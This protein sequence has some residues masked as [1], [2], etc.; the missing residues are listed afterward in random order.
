M[1]CA[2]C[3]AACTDLTPCRQLPE[4]GGPAPEPAYNVARILTLSTL[5][6]ATLLTTACAQPEPDASPQDAA[7][8][9]A[10]SPDWPEGRLDRRVVPTAY[11]LELEILPEQATFEGR[12]R[13]DVA[14]TEA[15]DHVFMHGQALEVTRA[16]VTGPDG[17]ERDARWT[18]LGS[19]GVARLDLD[20]PLAAGRYRIDISYTGTFREGVEGLY[21][22]TLGDDH[23]AFTQFQPI[24]A[25]LV[26][27]GF[28]DPQFK[29]PFDISVVT[30]DGHAVLTTTAEVRRTEVEGG[31]VRISF[32]ET[33]PLPTYLIAF[34]VGPLDVVDAPALP[35]TEVRS[36]PLPLRGA[37]TRGKGDQLSFALR[38][39][40]PIL[41]QLEDYFGTP[42]P[43][44]K[45]DLIA[46]PDFGFAAMENVGAIIY[47]D[48][49]LLLGDT[50]PPL[51]QLRS[52]G[53]VHAHELAHQWFGNLV[54]PVWWTDIWLNESFANWM[55]NRTAALWR[56]DLEID[57][58]NVLEALA[59]MNADARVSARAVREPISRNQ[60]IAASFD[61]IT[62]QKGGGVLSMME[63]FM[64]AEAFRASVRLHMRRHANGNATAADFATSLAEGSG[65]PEL[66]PA[67]MSFIEQSGVPL[68]DV[69][70]VCA[71]DEAYLQVVQS[72][73]LPLG[74]AGSAQRRWSIPACFE[75]DGTVLCRVIDDPEQRIALE[76]CPVVVLPN[77]DGAGYYRFSLPGPYWRALLEDPSR[78][79]EAEL[80]VIADSLGAAFEADRMDFEVFAAAAERLADHPARQVALKPLGL[81]RKVLERMT[82]GA[83]RTAMQRWLARIYG[84]SLSQLGYAPQEGDSQ[85]ERL[86]RVSLAEV[87]AELAEDPDAQQAYAA[88]G[89][90][91]IGFD[92]EAADPSAVPAD[93]R[94]T[95]FTAAIALDGTPYAEG[96]LKQFLASDD[97]YFRAQ[98]LAALARNDD[99]QFARTLRE[100]AMGDALGDSELGNLIFGLGA[101]ETHRDS[102]LAWLEQ[103][104]DRIAARL[105]FFFKQGLPGYTALY[106]DR[107]RGARAEA[108]FGAHLDALPGGE[109]RLAEAAEAVQ[110]CAAL[111]ASKRGEVLAYFDRP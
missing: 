74:S 24:G 15:L 48:P 14:F 68:L 20:E 34:A 61:G 51:G 22:T 35:P 91:N 92:G 54:T 13:I 102:T 87:L 21:K 25:R 83:A 90:A 27:P 81:L 46:S 55:G 33:P 8:S 58:Y 73:Y 111:V 89:R 18:E 107:D 100:L 97:R 37:A 75:V 110:L 79:N 53:T 60:D 49:L 32:E 106:C 108:F 2:R 104:L 16:V 95:A 64:G 59:A 40:A 67:F 82:D 26:F 4:P 10:L 52:F 23:Y 77:D 28:D 44:P 71:D 45:L 42:H 101:N 57:N 3:A 93:L 17:L 50:D 88:M 31:R 7:A 76:Q 62:Y 99:P 69:T 98:A 9:A 66:V 78:W 47:G 84:P 85:A 63:R 103:D 5:V 12:V 65:R 1:P 43:Y 36:A 38:N 6:L 11:D 30:R 96:L 29:T 72:R 56:P 105:P 109:R 94:D 86:R 80:L 70:P 41:E 19:Q 39:T